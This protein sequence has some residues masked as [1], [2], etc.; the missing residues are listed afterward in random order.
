MIRNN[1]QKLLGFSRHKKGRLHF[2]NTR[3]GI[4]EISYQINAKNYF[5][6]KKFFKWTSLMF[7]VSPM[8]LI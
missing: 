6:D 4:K 5:K 8:L 2:R 3:N 1:A 7:N